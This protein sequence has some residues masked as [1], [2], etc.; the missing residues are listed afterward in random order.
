MSVALANGAEFALEDVLQELTGVPD[1]LQGKEAERW[2]CGVMA[3]LRMKNCGREELAWLL[4]LPLESINEDIPSSGSKELL[5]FDLLSI[6][7]LPRGAGCSIRDCRTL[8]FL[9]GRKC[10]LCRDCTDEAS[11]AFVLVE[12]GPGEQFGQ[13]DLGKPILIA[14]KNLTYIVVPTEASQEGCPSLDLYSGEDQPEPEFG[15][16]EFLGDQWF[17]NADERPSF[18]MPAEAWLT[19]VVGNLVTSK[20]IGRE[21][22][23][24]ILSLPKKGS[25][26]GFGGAVVP[27]SITPDCYDK[28]LEE[29][30]FI[31]SSLYCLVLNSNSY[32]HFNGRHCYLTEPCPEGATHAAVNLDGEELRIHRKNLKLIREEDANVQRTAAPLV[33]AEPKDDSKPPPLAVQ[34]ESTSVSELVPGCVPQN[35]SAPLAGN[36]ASGDLGWFHWLLSCGACARQE[37]AKINAAPSLQISAVAQSQPNFCSA[38]GHPF[39][40][41]ARFCANCGRERV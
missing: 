11:H 34:Q 41:G 35:G 2:L 23:G 19:R 21:E 5:G 9:N 38:C 16:L 33:S 29:L 12:G 15:P 14:R 13:E 10:T 4:N 7:F 17:D 20:G 39:S 37:P 25:S 40:G 3:H 8:S 6:G 28:M 27:S 31:P 24:Y 30:G 32:A 1:F 36:G 18:L 22:L 26:Q